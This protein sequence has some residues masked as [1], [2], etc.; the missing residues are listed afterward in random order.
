MI[1]RAIALVLGPAKADEYKVTGI[2]LG[3]RGRRVVKRAGVAPERIHLV[4]S[5]DE[6]GAARDQLAAEIEGGAPLLLV[7]ATGWVVAGELVEPLDGDSEAPR[8][9]VDEAG[10]FAGAVL[11]SGDR[12][13]ELLDAVVSDYAA[14]DAVVLAWDEA[15]SVTVNRRARHPART[16]AE[17]KQADAWQFEL[18]N[19]PLDAWLV[20][21]FYRPAAR[22]F[23][24]LFLRTPMTPNMIS[25]FSCALSLTGCAIAAGSS[26]TAHVVGLLVLLAGG[27]ID[28]C[29]GEVARLRLE[30]SKVGAWLDAIGD[31]MAR[32]ALIAAVG[33]HVSSLHTD[34]PILW[35]TAGAIGFTLASMVLIYWYCIFVIGSSNNQDYGVLLGIGPGENGGKRTFGQLLGDFGA[36]V[37]RRDFID[38]CALGFAFAAVPEASFVALVAGS[39]IGFA[40]VLP[41]HLKIVAMESEKR[42]AANDNDESIVAE[43]DAPVVAKAEVVARSQ[44]AA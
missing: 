22:P 20:V 26:W 8:Y 9:S 23:T 40:V 35:I 21:N 44:R 15:R 16:K 36:S 7:R 34:L 42:A 6:L 30:Q 38:L 19:K 12:A 28:A 10:D 1:E 25:I 18:V 27:I 32:L 17:A 3:E 13:V 5:A 41:T 29:D 43:V 37:A 39:V 11:C 24:R 33:F 4:R 14:G 31:D 2:T